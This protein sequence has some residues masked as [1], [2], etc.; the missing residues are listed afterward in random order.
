MRNRT[1]VQALTVR[2]IFQ[3]N[4]KCLK[5][6]GRI[7]TARNYTAS[8][9]NF[10][11]FLM[12]AH[13]DDLAIGELDAA[14]VRSYNLWL[15]AA[16]AAPNSVSFY[17]RILRALFNKA[18][19]QGLVT[20]TY[21]FAEAFTGT[22]PTRKK[23]LDLK[24]LQRIGSLDLS[25]DRNLCLTRDL[26]LFSFFARGMSFVDMAYLTRKDVSAGVICYR[27]RKTGT[28]MMVQIEPCMQEIMDRYRSES[29]ANFVFPVIHTTSREEAYAQYSYG[30]N[31]CNLLLKEIGHRAKIAFPLNTNAAR[32]SWATL[33]RDLNI[34]VTVISA[35]M[36][37]SQ[38]RTTRVY[39]ETLPGSTVDHANRKLLDFY[40]S[41]TK[42][43]SENAR[44]MY[45]GRI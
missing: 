29:S 13:A 4:I 21:P 7:G 18:V 14:V 44:E 24:S 12:Y 16:G 1:A 41:K 23:A 38:E 37:H 39:L 25:E 32:H 30:L 11:A 42:E 6:E 15:R 34:P 17:N 36:G 33:A 19:K 43:K 20:Q 40:F 45:Q 5:D 31:R 35:G 9:K 3:E 22:D 26:F 27:R 28:R 2:A 10:S 8:L